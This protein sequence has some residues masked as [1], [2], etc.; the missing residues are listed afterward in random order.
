MR[1]SFDL[2]LPRIVI[3][4]LS[5]R[6]LGC[7]DL[8][9]QS[10]YVIYFQHRCGR[11]L[12]VDPTLNSE[13]DVKDW[14]GS[15]HHAV[16]TECFPDEF[17]ATLDDFSDAFSRAIPY[18]ASEL[19]A[20]VRVRCLE[21]LTACFVSNFWLLFRLERTLIQRVSMAHPRKVVILPACLWI[22]SLGSRKDV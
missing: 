15:W 18:S 2:R 9:E 7:A 5:A 22:V 17:V 20:P 3:L 14:A 13:V 16:V 21:G 19:W 6:V 1:S 4:C 11:T 8:A 12:F 10:R